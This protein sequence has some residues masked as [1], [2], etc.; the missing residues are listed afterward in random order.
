M[1]A[2]QAVVRARRCR[3][4]EVAV[5][6]SRMAIMV[7]VVVVVVEVT[8]TTPLAGRRS[9]LD[10]R[11]RGASALPTAQRRDFFRSGSRRG[12][13]GGQERTQVRTV[14]TFRV[15]FD[16]RLLS[17]SPSVVGRVVDR[18]RLKMG[19][20][21]LLQSS[22]HR[23][24]MQGTGR[25]G[26]HRTQHQKWEKGRGVVYRHAERT[27]YYVLH[28]YRHHPSMPRIERV[29]YGCKNSTME[30]RPVGLATR[31]GLD[32]PS[33]IITSRTEPAFHPDRSDGS[34]AMRPL[35]RRQH[36]ERRRCVRSTEVSLQCRER[37]A[38]AA[39]V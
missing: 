36:N 27:A 25:S 9:A 21:G 20:L 38:R 33:T 5:A 7:V 13:I 30:C 2:I 3:G 16:A 29:W 10:E 32:R 14:L 6:T 19:W 28:T 35:T 23:S 26:G 24:T 34:F 18:P 4:R 12:M 37:H 39:L 22:T 15:C 11:T 8:T 17:V 1:W 31:R